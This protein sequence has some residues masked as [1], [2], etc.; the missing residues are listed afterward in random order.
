MKRFLL[1]IL[2]VILVI[3][4]AKAQTKKI[5][6]LDS[7]SPVIEK[8]S[9]GHLKFKGKLEGMGMEDL[10][11]LYNLDICQYFRLKEYDTE[12]KRKAFKTTSEGKEL[13][14]E[15]EV[16]KKE[17][18]GSNLYYVYPFESNLGWG[19]QYNLKTKTFD[20]SYIMNWDDF[21]PI[22]GYANVDQLAFKCPSAIKQYSK[23]R[24]Y[25]GRYSYL[26]TLKIPMTE[27]QALPI[28][29]NIKNMAL[30]VEFK[31]QKGRWNSRKAS[32]FN[33]TTFIAQ[34][35]CSNIYL[36]D[37]NTNEIYFSL[38]PVASVAASSNVEGRILNDSAERQGVINDP[39]G[40]T[41]IRKS[42]NSKSE[43]IGKVMEG[44]VF[45]YWE[46]NDNWYVVQTAKG[47]KGF[48]YKNRIKPM[49]K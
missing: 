19:K 42:N 11:H 27:K 32:M 26:N 41:N 21:F 24:Y 25:S 45:T 43:I 10:Y 2:V 7:T 20:F 33:I 3:V 16:K 35:T 36:I 40:Y 28:E 6:K 5:L 47:I 15:L 1:S 29:E 49:E 4:G 37:K 17:I 23:E 34:G 30:V 12:L 9:Y 44:E 8:P 22:Q 38:F 48:I 39:D 14:K 13:L 46:T 31:Y 18:I